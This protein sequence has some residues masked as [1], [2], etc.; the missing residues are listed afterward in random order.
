MDTVMLQAFDIVKKEYNSDF[1]CEDPENCSKGH[2]ICHIHKIIK[3]DGGIINATILRLE[4][5]ST[6][7]T[8]MLHEIMKFQLPKN[9]IEEKGETIFIESPILIKAMYTFAG[10][11]RVVIIVRKLAELKSYSLDS[12][13]KEFN[14]DGTLVSNM[15]LFRFRAGEKNIV[16]IDEFLDIIRNPTFKAM[17]PQLANV[18]I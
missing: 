16:F 4:I 1:L 9:I 7:V 13:S 15:L 10:V 6:F 11:Y 14:V 3:M 8:K 12:F 17:A 18:Q 2:I 5:V